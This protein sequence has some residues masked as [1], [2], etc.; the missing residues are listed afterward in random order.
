[1]KQRLTIFHKINKETYSN[2]TAA[3]HYFHH[4]QLPQALKNSVKYPQENDIQITKSKSKTLEISK[5][6]IV[7]I[8]KLQEISAYRN[9][10]QTVRIHKSHARGI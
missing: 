8:L 3:M 4:F 10:I 7:Q 2:Q 1:M 5:K 9:N 6:R